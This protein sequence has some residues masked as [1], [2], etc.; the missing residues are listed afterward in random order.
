MRK[1]WKKSILTGA[2]TAS[3]LMT[4]V[5][6]SMAA[7]APDGKMPAE[8]MAG[9]MALGSDWN[10]WQKDWEEIK[11]DWTQIAL[12]PGS[13]AS[14]LNFAWYSKAE[15]GVPKLKI[16]KGKSIRNAKIYTATQ[17]DVK[18]VNGNPVENVEDEGATYKANKVTAKGL[19]ENTT[20]YY[21][22]EK[23]GMWTE[24]EA[25]RTKD[26]KS[27]HFIFVGDP[28]IGSSNEEKAKKPEDIKKNSFKTAQS[29]S[30]R[31]DSFNWNTTLEE[32]MAQTDDQ[33]S[34]VLSAGDQIQTNAKKVKDYS[35]SEVEYAGYLSPDILK[36]LPVA[37][38]VG[39][40]D[41]D[42]PNYTYHFNPA[43]VSKLGSNGIVGGDYSFTYGD[44][45]FLM[46]NTQ[47]TN[48]AEHQQF[49]EKA[50]QENPNCKWRIATLH[51]DIYGS[52]EHSNEPE[53]VNLRYQLVPVFEKNDIDVVLTGHDHAY[54]RSKMLYSDGEKTIDY[55]DDAFDAQLEKDL[56]VGDSKEML[57]TA[58]A[59]IKEDTT[60]PDEQAYL[61]YLNQIMDAD[62]VEEVKK[63]GNAVL[64]PDGILYMTANSASGSKFYD[65]VPR[66]QTYIANRWQQDVP[67][68]SVVDVDDDTLTINTY[69][70]DNNEKIDESFTIMKA[71]ID[72]SS[73][74]N[75]IDS[76]KAKEEKEKAAYTKESYQI[77]EAALNGAVA[78]YND[79]KATTEEV[80]SAIRALAEAKAALK[81][82]QVS[83][84][85]KKP[86]TTTQVKK[87]TA[88]K[89]AEI[90]AV[91]STGK[92]K[93]K[94][95]IKKSSEKVAGYQMKYASNK[96]FKHAKT[97]TT[98]K[99]VYQLKSL[100]SKKT[101]YIKVRA[102]KNVSGK[103]IYG[104]YSKVVK[105]KVK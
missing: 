27:F 41:S 57:T 52:A 68:Y 46:L 28:Q 96:K 63:E 70:T 101:Y 73:L 80:T 61:N 53:I 38:T 72:K 7:A 29:E 15:E 40:H 6:P 104:Q 13:D 8:T 93:V 71:D 77:F 17:T 2:L 92:K 24:P 81:K 54:S 51:Q 18:D 3:I 67:T 97:K 36:S 49:I 99:T 42:N 33:A 20:Y 31:S 78:V 103:K 100:T 66:K 60:D 76:A 59:N 43:N 87:E 16:G 47:D 45:L 1:K 25:Y 14:E 98:T 26:T 85:E 90:K 69:R 75:A 64:N 35:V 44:A 23:D 37:T 56:D 50:I 39:N 88:P 94:V 74:K 32:A 102:Y 48:V 62:A 105:V 4:N 82:M 83:T 91:K 55:T 5:V 11:T 9:S 22:Y 21:S 86:E 65:L 79:K 95:T 84:S 10:Q 30:V 89:K 58:P 34:F 19:K 12:S